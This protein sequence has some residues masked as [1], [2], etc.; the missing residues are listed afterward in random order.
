[1][2]FAWDE[3]LTCPTLVAALVVPVLSCEFYAAGAPKMLI[4]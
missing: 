3:C 2:Y 4:D 1:M